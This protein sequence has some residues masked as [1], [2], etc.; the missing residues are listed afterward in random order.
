MSFS[1]RLTPGMSSHGITLELSDSDVEGC[2]LGENVALGESRESKPVGLDEELLEEMW[3]NLTTYEG[4]APGSSAVADKAVAEAAADKAVAEAK[5]E[6]GT[7]IAAEE[8]EDMAVEA[9]DE[10]PVVEMSPEELDEFHD[11]RISRK[12]LRARYMVF[13]KSVEGKLRANDCVTEDGI[14]LLVDEARREARGEEDPLSQLRMAQDDIR[15]ICLMGFEA[16]PLGRLVQGKD[17]AKTLETASKDLVRRKRSLEASLMGRMDSLEKAMLCA[18]KKMAKLLGA[19]L[20]FSWFD[21]PHNS[22]HMSEQDFEDFSVFFEGVVME[23]DEA[24]C[25]QG[26]GKTIFRKVLQ[27]ADTNLSMIAVLKAN[28]RREEHAVYKSLL[29][30]EWWKRVRAAAPSV[31]SA[32]AVAPRPSASVAVALPADPSPVSSS[33]PSEALAQRSSQ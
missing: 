11:G 24:V 6:V 1:G 9:E 10:E 22:W 5:D 25:L 20:S 2:L 3:S 13:A 18:K 33:V 29:K 12:R 32:V 17:L 26:H 7:D 8:N 21:S 15:R 19:P 31:I 27:D 30:E 23:F 16:L 28:F 4:A 14:L